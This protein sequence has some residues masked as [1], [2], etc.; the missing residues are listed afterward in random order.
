[1]RYISEFI[2]RMTQENPTR[3]YTRIQG[4]LANLGHKAAVARL[5]MC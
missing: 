3:G 5:P 4:A 2:V 1:M